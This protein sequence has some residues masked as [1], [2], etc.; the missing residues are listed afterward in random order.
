MGF[1][2]RQPD[3]LAV[4]IQ[5]PKYKALMAKLLFLQACLRENQELPLPLRLRNNK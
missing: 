3:I 2:G 4:I 5:M 1:T